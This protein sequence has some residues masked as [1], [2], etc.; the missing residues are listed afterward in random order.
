[1][2]QNPVIDGLPAIEGYKGK[3]AEEMLIHLGIIAATT[4]VRR[5]RRISQDALDKYEKLFRL[6]GAL[7]DAID[8]RKKMQGFDTDE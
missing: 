1:M 2:T 4:D 3:S 6:V 5:G 7:K 8:H